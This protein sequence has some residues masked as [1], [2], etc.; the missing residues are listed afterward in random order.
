MDLNA[1]IKMYAGYVAGGMIALV[2]TGAGVACLA[3]GNIAGVGI[4]ASSL[5]AA[6]VV[7]R[8]FTSDRISQ[9]RRTDVRSASSGRR[10]I[11]DNVSR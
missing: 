8:W 4:I 11:E 6:N 10:R 2:G 9:I 5:S 3:T 7:A 1:L